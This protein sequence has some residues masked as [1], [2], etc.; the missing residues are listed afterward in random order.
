MKV[1]DNFKHKFVKGLTCE[2]IDFTAK[3][4]KVKQTEKKKSK[5]AFFELV[6]FE[7]SDRGVWEKI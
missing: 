1:G 6:Y 4:V 2:I 5:Q 3:G 7:Q